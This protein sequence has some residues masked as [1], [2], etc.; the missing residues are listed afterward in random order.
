MKYF[1]ISSWQVLLLVIVVLLFWPH[2][3]WYFK[4]W[5]IYVGICFWI[6]VC[7]KSHIAYLTFFNDWSFLRNLNQTYAQKFRLH[8]CKYPYTY[9]SFLTLQTVT[10]WNNPVFCS[11]TYEIPYSYYK[12]YHERMSNIN[13]F[14]L[15]INLQKAL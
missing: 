4:H 7:I 15:A 6:T 9:V 12:P 2:K 8:I 5:R 1:V 14:F 11:E 13:T 3:P 10:N